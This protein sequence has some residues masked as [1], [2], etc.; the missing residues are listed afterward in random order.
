[1]A[2]AEMASY[3]LRTKPLQQL[4]DILKCEKDDRVFFII[5]GMMMM[6]K[7]MLQIQRIHRID[8]KYAG[9]KSVGKS[10]LAKVACSGQTARTNPL[11]VL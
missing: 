7:K 5:T 8:P 6:A 11:I 9:P 3:V 1:M 10:T 2:S 4:G